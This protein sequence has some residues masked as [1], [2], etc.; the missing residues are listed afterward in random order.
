MAAICAPE[1]WEAAFS[2]FWRQSSAQGAG[3][4]DDYQ[5]RELVE[6]MAKAIGEWADCAKKWEI[7]DPFDFARMGR[8]LVAGWDIRP[9]GS[10]AL[11]AG[12]AIEKLATLL[13][14]K[15]PDRAGV[16]LL[17]VL[18]AQTESSAKVGHAIW[19]RA[20][21]AG[22]QVSLPDAHPIFEKA[23]GLAPELANHPIW[24]EI[25]ELVVAKAASSA[26]KIRL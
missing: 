26:R 12:P 6:R 21:E 25:E 11:R 2:E 1:Q 13:C 22:A 24:R 10:R 8:S 14:V 5:D 19:R 23:G 9:D 18:A 20:L 7:D 15:F 17:D 16:V 4:N 3:S